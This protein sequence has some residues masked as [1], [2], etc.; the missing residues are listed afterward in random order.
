MSLWTSLE[1]AS[2]TV[3]PGGSTTVRLR[4]RNTGDVV[5][6]Y[7]FETVGGLAP[8]TVVEPPT[9]RLYP[10]TT[11]SVD[12]TFAPPRTPDAT[13]GPNPYAVRITPTEHPEAT[14]VP[15]GNLAITPFTEVRAELVPPTVKGRFRGRPKLAVDNLGNTKLTASVSGSDNGDQLSYDIHPSNVQIEPGR[16]AFVKTTLKPKQVIW[17]GSKESRPYTLAVQRSGVDPLGVEGTY[18]QRSFL[19]R[20]LATF[21]GIFMALAITF[22]ML[23]IAYKPNVRSTATEKL[24]EAGISTLPPSP[25]ASPKAPKAPSNVPTPP[26]AATGTR[27]AD[28]SAAG[29]GGGG[30]GDKETKAPERTAATAVQKL[31]AQDPTGRHICY[32]AYVSGQGWTEAVCDGETAGTVGKETPLKAVNIAVS[33]TKGTSS[34]AFVHNPGSTNG[35]GHF[36]DPWSGAADGIDNYVGSTKKD[37]PNM[38]GLTVNVGGGAGSVCQTAHVHNDGWLG[39][40]CD[41]PKSGFDFTYAGTHNND[42][43]LEAIKLTV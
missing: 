12:V 37:A 21:L 15:E 20:W 4:L 36:P 10:G 22:V 13:A 24:H 35:E 2:A 31:A 6:E 18:V 29:A 25:T 26:P 40:E 33:G 43:W 16:A 7:R 30:S 41:D 14:T 34:D 38:L 17:F 32:R 8:W 11:G 28:G 39:L 1:P 23:W 27:Q 19:P 3:D 5:D 42:L 9:L